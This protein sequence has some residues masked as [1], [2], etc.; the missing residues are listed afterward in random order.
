[1]SGKAFHRWDEEAKAWIPTPQSESAEVWKY[2]PLFSGP[3][4]DLQMIATPAEGEC[5]ACGVT[6]LYPEG[7]EDTLPPCPHCGHTH[8]ETT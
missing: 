7:I 3:A 6:L 2:K 8:G 4:V 5:V 1:M